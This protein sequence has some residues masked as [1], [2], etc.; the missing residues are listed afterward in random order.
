ML[1]YLP[2]VLSGEVPS[3][4]I[5]PGLRS[6]PCVLTVTNL[7]SYKDHLPYGSRFE[8]SSNSPSV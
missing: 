6:L 7:F 2:S 3:L 5:H 4:L 1:K 8:D